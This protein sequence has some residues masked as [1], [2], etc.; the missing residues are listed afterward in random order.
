MPYVNLEFHG[1]LLDA[2]DNSN[3]AAFCWHG[4]S[5]DKDGD[6]VPESRVSQNIIQKLWYNDITLLNAVKD[7][8]A[9]LVT[10]RCP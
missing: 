9:G 1:K 10:R 2:V 5:P 6:G 3:G 4:D 8:A 7:V